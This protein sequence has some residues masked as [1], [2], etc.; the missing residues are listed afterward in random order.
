VDMVNHADN[1]GRTALYYAVPGARQD[2]F[3]E[4]LS[5][6]RITSGR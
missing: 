3:Q 6:E 4:G 2:T 1:M 5:H